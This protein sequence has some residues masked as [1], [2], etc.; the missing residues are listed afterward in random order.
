MALLPGSLAIDAGVAVSGVTTDQRGVSQPRGVPRTSA[1][2]S[3]RF[4]ACLR[5]S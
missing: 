4:K 1:R 2:S 5:R 3:F